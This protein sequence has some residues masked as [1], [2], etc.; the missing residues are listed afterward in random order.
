[1]TGSSSPALSPWEVVGVIAIL[2]T[3]TAGIVVI[4]KICDTLTGTLLQLLASY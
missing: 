1:M 3:L 4:I 2:F